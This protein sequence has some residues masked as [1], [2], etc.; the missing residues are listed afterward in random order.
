MVMVS[1]LFR[2]LRAPLF[3]MVLYTINHR[4]FPEGHRR[5]FSP[6]PEYFLTAS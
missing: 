1:F 3:P 2:R 4:C 5:L 6:L